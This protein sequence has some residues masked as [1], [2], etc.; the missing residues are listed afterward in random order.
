MPRFRAA[1]VA[2]RG[3]LVWELGQTCEAAGNG[4]VGKSAIKRFPVHEFWILKK[5]IQY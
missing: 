1:L 5:Y 3:I 4:M 2:V